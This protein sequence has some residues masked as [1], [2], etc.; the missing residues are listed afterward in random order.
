M[1]INVKDLHNFY[2]LLSN[3]LVFQVNVR[4]SDCSIIE[5]SVLDV[6]FLVKEKIRAKEKNTYKNCYLKSIESV[7]FYCLTMY[8]KGLAC[9]IWFDFWISSFSSG[10]NLISLTLGAPQ[11]WGC[12]SLFLYKS[13]RM[14]LCLCV[15]K[16]LAN[17]KSKRDDF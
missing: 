1:Y 10:S 14:S 2:A 11:R 5:L 8:V 17:H 13:N 7:L 12:V 3:I 16:D 15:P 6:A 9:D 4:L